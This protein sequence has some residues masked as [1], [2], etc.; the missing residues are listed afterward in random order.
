MGS[1]F[2]GHKV[3]L[4]SLT[5]SSVLFIPSKFINSVIHSFR[6]PLPQFRIHQTALM[7]STG[8]ILWIFSAGYKAAKNVIIN[9]A[10]GPLMAEI[11]ESFG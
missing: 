2:K 3:A 11:H 7:A 1:G 8:C 9:T 6:L 10:I 5:S 4:F